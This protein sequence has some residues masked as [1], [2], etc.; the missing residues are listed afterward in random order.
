MGPSD[1]L[2]TKK[3]RIGVI[4]MDTGKLKALGKNNIAAVQAI[5]PIVKISCNASPNHPNHPVK[6]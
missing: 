2:I 6:K 1:A 4:M 3:H 5:E